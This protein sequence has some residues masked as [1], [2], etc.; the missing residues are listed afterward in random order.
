MRYHI[1]TPV[2][3]TRIVSAALL[4][5]LSAAAW[6]LDVNDELTAA[7]EKYRA[8]DLN[9]ALKR[10]EPLLAATDLDQPTRQRVHELAARVLQSRGEEYFRQGRIGE[11]I[12]DFERQIK[13][14][15]DQ[16]AGHWQ[17]GIAYYDAG[18]YQKGAK[19]FELHK[20]VNPQDVENAAWHFLCVVRS[21]GGSIEAARKA[22][23]DVARDSRVPMA[24]IQQMFA[25]KTTPEEVLQT[26]KDAG[27]AAKFYADLYVGLYFEALG[28]TDE[29]LRLLTLAADNPAAKNSYMGD[30]A[31]VHVALRKK[32]AS[33]T[34]PLKGNRQREC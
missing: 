29:S 9:S 32:A 10:L 18:E 15:P 34:Q 6:A 19:Q 11:S 7:Q 2:L 14:Q 21:P 22:L 4:I 8:G 24:Q 25:G 28:K 5:S 26:G 33:K 17:L 30:V 31:R 20:T 27:G 1:P 13:L 23:I 3:A 16:A 12:S